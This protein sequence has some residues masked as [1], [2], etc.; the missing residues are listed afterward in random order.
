MVGCVT[1][2]SCIVWERVF[3]SI[4]SSVGAKLM[5][6]VTFLFF[7]SARGANWRNL[8]KNITQVNWRASVFLPGQID[9]FARAR[10]HF[11]Q[12][13]IRKKLESCAFCQLRFRRLYDIICLSVEGSKTET[14]RAPK[15]SFGNLLTNPPK[16][17]IIKLQKD[18]VSPK[19]QKGNSYDY[20]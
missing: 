12:K 17:G 5:K 19:N 2:L 1:W 15:K 10:R 6:K 11:A 7:R 8:L 20:S 13:P 16:C 18:K 3:S 4:C 14:G 9:V